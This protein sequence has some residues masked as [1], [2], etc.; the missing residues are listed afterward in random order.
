M[1]RVSVLIPAKNAEATLLDCLGSVNS[2]TFRDFD[3]ILVADVVND[4]LQQIAMTFQNVMSVKLI[5]QG[6]KSGLSNA[7]NCG[8]DASDSEFI[9][10]LDADD[11][12][13][14]DRIQKQVTFMDDDR[15]VDVCGSDMLLFEDFSRAPHS[16]LSRPRE[17]ATIKTA[18]I[19][20]NS[21]LH[22]SLICRRTFFDDV[23]CY[24]TRFKFAEDYDLWCRGSL[25][26]KK[27]ANIPE[28]LTFYRVHPLQTTQFH[29]AEN[30]A[31]DLV[32]KKKYMSALLGKDCGSLAEFFSPLHQFEG[33]L[34]FENVILSILPL[35]IEL[36][37]KI[38]DQAYY[39]RLLGETTLRQLR[40]LRQA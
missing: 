4:L 38:P 34:A 20:M 12:M 26:G 35:A 16:V 8:L 9:L 13:A 22:P 23:G 3:V 28:C 15:T 39:N 14:S 25:F 6:I 36:G 27:Y 21:L 2:S 32:V 5:N 30:T 19:Q 40:A 29:A 33:P 10:R 1:P 11:M 37:N 18:L 17:S 24:D 7:L 31:F